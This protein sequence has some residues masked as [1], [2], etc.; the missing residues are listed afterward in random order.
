MEEAPL[1]NLDQVEELATMVQGIQLANRQQLDDVLSETVDI[2]H[3]TI[4][5]S[6][7]WS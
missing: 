6:V 1:L 3:T 5:S 2:H 7:S 4:I